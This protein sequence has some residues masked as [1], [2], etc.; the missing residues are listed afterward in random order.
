MTP[1]D[2]FGEAARAGRGDAIVALG[3]GLALC[4][5]VA[6]ARAASPSGLVAGGLVA[7]WCVYAGGWTVLAAFGALVVGG[8]AASRA[9]LAR[10][11]ELGVAEGGGGRRSARHVVANAGPATL[12]LC[13]AWWAARNGDAATAAAF[14]VAAAAALLGALTD[15]ASGE[16]G[17]L[18][19]ATPRML[20]L[21]RPVARG[22]DGGM[23]WAGLGLG[24]CVGALGAAVVVAA[25]GAAGDSAADRAAWATLAAAAVCGTVCDSVFGACGERR[26]GWGNEVTNFASSA[27]AGLA[28]YLLWKA[29][30]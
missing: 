22:T 5:P 12:W 26:F 1:A 4:V 28:A 14:R 3:V 13:G 18:T 8:T 21:G 11:R 15:T 17:M 10:K 19:R 30:A 16:L 29:W 20:L 2:V 23:T 27:C 6:L 9:G 24:A 7:A 25:A